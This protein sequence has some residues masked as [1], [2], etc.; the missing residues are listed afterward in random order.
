MTA[1]TLNGKDDVNYVCRVYMNDFVFARAAEVQ[2][3]SA[4]ERSKVR[5]VFKSV[6]AVLLYIKLAASANGGEA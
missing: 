4:N 6:G 1:F 5:C 2:T 3:F